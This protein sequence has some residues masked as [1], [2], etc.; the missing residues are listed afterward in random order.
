MLSF[1]GLTINIDGVAMGS[2]GNV[3]TGHQ[4]YGGRIVLTQM[5]VPG[6]SGTSNS[7]SCIDLPMACFQGTTTPKHNLT[8]YLCSDPYSPQTPIQHFTC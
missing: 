2:A 8:G 3:M 6:G 5:G 1:E 4:S 7:W